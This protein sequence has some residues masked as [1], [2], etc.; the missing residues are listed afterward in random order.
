MR[1]QDILTGYRT[2]ALEPDCLNSNPCP[3]LIHLMT[4]S[5]QSFK[6]GLLNLG[7]M[8][9]LWRLVNSDGEKIISLF[10]LTSK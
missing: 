5:L 8:K 7:S 10:S 9:N 1:V 4:E 2:W 6:A 3:P